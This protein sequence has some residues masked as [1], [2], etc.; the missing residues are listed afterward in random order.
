[1]VKVRT[2]STQIKCFEMLNTPSYT[3]YILHIICT[4]LHFAEK[5]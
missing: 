5:A 3:Y 1:M 4:D 2:F